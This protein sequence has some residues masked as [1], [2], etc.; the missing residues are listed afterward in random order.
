MNSNHKTDTPSVP[1]MKSAFPLL[2]ELDMLADK[3]R[4][5]DDELAS[6]RS[7]L[8]PCDRDAGQERQEDERVNQSRQKELAFLIDKI[9]GL[10]RLYDLCENT[11]LAIHAEKVCQAT[12]GESVVVEL[13]ILE[14]RIFQV[15]RDINPE[16]Y[17]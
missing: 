14:N 6:A 2:N 4:L 17:T 13:G 12:R 1:A 10:G 16:Q 3:W 7:G 9:T 11:M 15:L 5:Q 8:E